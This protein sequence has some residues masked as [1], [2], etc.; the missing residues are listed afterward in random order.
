[1]C[2]KVILTVSLTC[3]AKQCLHFTDEGC[4]KCL[5]VGEIHL[6]TVGQCYELMSREKED[7]RD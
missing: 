7:E 5:K 2:K 4:K 6:D 1:M 3:D